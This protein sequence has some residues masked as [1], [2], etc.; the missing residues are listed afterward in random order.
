MIVNERERIFDRSHH[1]QP[2]QIDLDDAH[3]GAVFLVPLH[4][5][6]AG[7]RGRLKR[8]DGIQLPLADDHAAGVLA[9]VA[10]QILHGDAELEELANARPLQ[11]EPGI[12]KLALE[13]VTRI[14]VLPR[15]HQASQTSERFFIESENL[16]DLARRRA[17]TIRDDVRRHRGAEFAIAFIYVLNRLLALVAAG[18]IEIDVGPLTALF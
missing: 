8:H 5:D 2:Q 9:E 14:L 15:T 11:L 12:A 4:H 6:A 1:A 13:R 7:H 16:A 17:P 3:V 18:K 10:R